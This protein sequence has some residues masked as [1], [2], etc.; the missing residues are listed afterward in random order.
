MNSTNPMIMATMKTRTSTGSTIATIDTTTLVMS[1]IVLATGAPK[2]TVVALITGRALAFI[3]CTVSDTSTPTTI[4]THWWPEKNAPGS[5]TVT[6]C[7]PDAAPN[8]SPPAV[9]RTTV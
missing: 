5:L 7:A 8:T 6:V 1:S 3:E 4:G 2:P 9:G